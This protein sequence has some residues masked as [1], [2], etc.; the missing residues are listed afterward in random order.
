[1]PPACG[2]RRAEEAGRFATGVRCVTG[3]RKRRQPRLVGLKCSVCGLVGTAGGWGAGGL[4]TS[5]PLG[6]LAGGSGGGDCS[7]R[8]LQNGYRP[9]RPLPQWAA[10]PPSPREGR[11]VE[12][13]GVCLGFAA[14]AA[15]CLPW[16]AAPVDLAGVEGGLT[17]GPR[18]PPSAAPPAAVAKRIPAAVA[19]RR[20]GTTPT[21][22]RGHPH[23]YTF[24]RPSSVVSDP[25]PWPCFATET[26]PAR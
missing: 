20:R 4:V 17:A 7:Q 15:E 18:G 25:V 6:P 23:P 11:A 1:M 21:S 13:G 3:G 16:S 24:C 22:T 14:A 8:R 5:P 9:L 2:A 19:T 12:A 10:A 26:C